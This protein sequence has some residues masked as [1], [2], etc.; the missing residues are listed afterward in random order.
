MYWNYFLNI[1]KTVSVSPF[2][3]AV[4]F[5]DDGASI[6]LPDSLT[7]VV[8]Q[9]SASAE[10]VVLVLTPEDE[11]TLAPTSYQFVQTQDAVEALIAVQKYGAVTYPADDSDGVVLVIDVKG[12]LYQSS[13]TATVEGVTTT[14]A[15]AVKNT[16]DVGDEIE[17]TPVPSE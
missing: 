15:T 9:K 16:A 5:V 3:N 11:A 6:S 13:T 10:S 12:T 17:F 14:T 2:S 1:Y 8:S 7:F 4:V